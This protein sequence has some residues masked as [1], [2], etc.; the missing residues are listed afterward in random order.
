MTAAPSW[1]EGL[2]ALSDG[3]VFEGEVLM[4]PG[5]GPAAGEVVFNTVMAGY[6]EVLTD[7]SYAG[8][9][10]VFTYPHIG[11]YGTAPDDDESRRPF[12]RGVI[13]RE[14]TSR[15][16]NWRAAEDLA[17]FLSRHGVA[18]MAGVD[19]RRLTKQLRE[20]GAMPGA[21]GPVDGAELAFDEE[22]LVAAAK[23]TPST[24][25]RDLV[26]E[27]TCQAPYELGEGRY[28][29]VAYDFGVK[30]NILRNLGS[31]ARV[32]VVPASTP[33]EEVLARSPDGVFLSNGPG[34]PAALPYATTAV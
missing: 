7:P 11:N 31:L 24:D 1:R 8:Q 14:L 15:P 28:R 33:A 27:V 32:T 21:F 3:S 2:L 5:G 6:Q 13:V 12:C 19:T 34:D 10:I 26:G 20:S 16:S 30:R 25:G 18:A 29:V 17:S 22:S 4:P 9:V 23:A